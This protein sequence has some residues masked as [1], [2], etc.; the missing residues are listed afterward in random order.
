M[1]YNYIKNFSF[2]THCALKFYLKNQ[3]FTKHVVKKKSV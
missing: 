3:A 2:L 1:K